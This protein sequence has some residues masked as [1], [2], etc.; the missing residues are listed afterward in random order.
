[1][2]ADESH[3]RCDILQIPHSEALRIN[4]FIHTR[5]TIDQYISLENNSNLMVSFSVKLLNI[6]QIMSFI[7]QDIH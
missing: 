4:N 5:E 3:C 6:K 2:T 7:G 1:M